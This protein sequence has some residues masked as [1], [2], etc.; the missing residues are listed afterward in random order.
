MRTKRREARKFPALKREREPPLIHC[1]TS[2]LQTWV[3]LTQD[4]MVCLNQAHYSHRLQCPLQ[5]IKASEHL[6]QRFHSRVTFEMETGSIEFKELK[7]SS[8]TEI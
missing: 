2:K 6:D 1:S 4:H 3:F 8:P 5:T 7:F